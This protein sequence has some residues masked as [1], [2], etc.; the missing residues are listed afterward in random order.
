MPFE[1]MFFPFLA[2][3]ALTSTQAAA[4]TTAD[5]YVLKAAFLYNFTLFTA[6]PETQGGVKL[7]VFGK[8]PFGDEL[9]RYAGRATPGGP[10]SV[11]KI[12]SIRE[13]RTC[14]LLFISSSEHARMEQIRDGLGEKPPLTVTEANGFDRRKVMIVLVTTGDRIAF[15]INLTAT[16][17]AGLRLDPK[18]LRL[19][20]GVY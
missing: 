3:L 17:Q 20:K 1:R 5:E 14:Q 11:A 10:V 8:D 18:L 13:A 7:C 16:R 15:E 4:H 12:D 19:A 6:W 2:A 9:N